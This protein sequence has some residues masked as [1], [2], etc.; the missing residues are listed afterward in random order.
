[1]VFTSVDV[2]VKLP[3]GTGP[4][5]FQIHGQTYHC[6]S[7]FY[8]SNAISHNMDNYIFYSA[9]ATKWIKNQ[10]NQAAGPKYCNNWARQM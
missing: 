7:L 6:V 4:Y 3:P 8:P 9:E 5:C 10:P 2:E 1:M